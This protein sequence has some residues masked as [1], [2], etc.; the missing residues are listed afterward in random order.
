MSGTAAENAGGGGL[1]VFEM[2]QIV[3][4]AC[5]MHEPELMAKTFL[6]RFLRVSFT[7]SNGA[8]LG[9]HCNK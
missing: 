9:C 3:Y 7:G 5:G 1:I 4:L 2:D 6:M 8:F